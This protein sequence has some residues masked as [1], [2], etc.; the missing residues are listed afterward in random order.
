MQPF[1]YQCYLKVYLLV[2]ATIAHDYDDVV[3]Q[4]LGD[5]GLTA[6]LNLCLQRLSLP[7]SRPARTAQS[8]SICAGL[9][10]T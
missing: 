2:W 3:A 9:V 6:A 8:A 4:C 10:M 7:L 5:H 1:G